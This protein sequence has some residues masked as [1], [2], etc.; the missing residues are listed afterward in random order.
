MTLEELK[1]ALQKF[2]GDT[3]RSQQETRDGLLDIAADAELLA[4][5]LEDEGDKED[6]FPDGDPR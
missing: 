5:G 3:S 1:E 2:F 6:M 4:E